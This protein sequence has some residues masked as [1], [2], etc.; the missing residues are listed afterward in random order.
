MGLR[1]SPIRFGIAGAIVLAV[2]G[3]AGLLAWWVRSGPSRERASATP[4]AE[5]RAR[6]DLASRKQADHVAEAPDDAAAIEERVSSARRASVEGRWRTARSIAVEKWRADILTATAL[7]EIG[8][9]PPMLTV[10]ETGS[11]VQLTNR[12]AGP[13]CVQ[14]ARVTRPNTDAV[15]R[16]QVGP[17]TC[18]MVKP[19]ATLRLHVDRS[20]AKDNCLNA[21]LEFRVGNVDFPEPSWWSRTAFNEFADRTLDISYKEEADL[22]A[23]IARFEAT[24]EDQGRAARWRQ[25]LAASGRNTRP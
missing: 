25:E 18:S 8:A 16:C 1:A 12:G 3:C 24:V 9:V 4:S 23:D 19:G 14:L 5:V 13:A 22:Q 10:R 7:G 20:G 15:E 21:A 17:A 11:L 2:I 6:R